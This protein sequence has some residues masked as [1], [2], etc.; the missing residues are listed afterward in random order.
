MQCRKSRVSLN[1]WASSSTTEP[2]NLI[3][4]S[5]LWNG[6]FSAR[7]RVPWD[8]KPGDRLEVKVLVK[9]VTSEI[10]GGFLSTFTLIASEEADDTTPPSGQ[11][12]GPT[13][14]H[15]N[16]K[17]TAQGLSI[18]EISEIRKEEWDERN[19][20]FTPYTALEVKHGMDGGYDFFLNVD[21]TY[22]LT[23]LSKASHVE[24]ATGW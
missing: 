16:G 13:R 8:A 10:R 15:K 5:H 23:A 22:L 20:K 4:H 18:P 17:E 11:P 2:A 21:N 12:S 9:D 1:N 14:P 3:E 7:V 6:Q 19:P 24:P